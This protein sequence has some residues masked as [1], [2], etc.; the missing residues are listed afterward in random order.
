MLPINR[1][2]PQGLAIA[3]QSAEFWRRVAPDLTISD[4]QPKPPVSRVP[5]LSRKER[6]MLVNDGFVHLKQPGLK[7]DYARLT[8]AI[9]RIIQ[10]GMPAAFIGVYDEVWSMA[11]QLSEVMNVMFGGKMQLMPDFRVIVRNPGDGGLAAHRHR[12][13]TALF[14]DGT[15][16]TACLWLPLT[17]AT[18]ANGCLY[19]IPAS[20]DRNYGKTDPA[21]AD[22]S[23]LAIRA[24][25]A[26]PGDALVLTGETYHW[27]ARPARRHDDGPQISLMWEFQSCD[28]APLEGMVVDSFPYVPFETRLGL[29]ARQ[30]PRQNAREL[31]GNP[32]W[33]AVQQTLANRYPLMRGGLRA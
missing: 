6:M 18:T 13:G 33:R 12:P 3:A 22:S 17:P 24:L 1:R 11:G 16:K 2:L 7:A 15:P 10:A 8:S 4:A 26:E 9:G 25:P 19:A 14:D 27:Q 31:S 32:V 30:M 20:Q 5:E 21:R 23:L 28:I 29:L